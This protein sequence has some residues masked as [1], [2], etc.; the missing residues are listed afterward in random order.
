[1]ASRVC[2]V[3]YHEI[4]LKGNNRARFERILMDNIKAALA[5][6]SVATITRI[7]G[8]ILVTF[9][10]SGEAERAFPLIAKVPGVARVSLAF[11]TNREPGEYCVAAI[12]ALEEFGEFNSFKVVARRSNTDYELTS[13]DL[14]KQVGE[15]LCNAFPDKKV[16]MKGCD[17]QVHVLVVQGSVYVYARSERGVGGLPQGSAGKV[18]TLLSSGIDSPVATWLLARRGAVPVPVHFSGRPQT[19]DTS[20]YLCQDIIQTLA[21]CVQVGRLYVIPFGDCQREI[22]IA[23]PSDLRVI[24]YRRVMYAVAERIA[25]LEGA[26]ALVTGESLGQVA[27][28]TLENIMAVNEVV[29][30]PVFRPLIGSD[31]Q[32][33]I[34]RAEQI[35][36]YDIS[37][38][39]A[40]D[41][42]TLFMP[43]RPETHAKL[44]EVHAAWEMFDHEAMIQQLVD[45]AEYI[46][47]SAPT[48]KPPRC[49]RERHDE[50]EIRYQRKSAEG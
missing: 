12:K 20:E 26:K 6:F 2:L 39:T 21:P 3:H 5:A 25:Q 42:C 33:I 41:C 36:T 43:R 14:N 1:M 45:A 4:G 10:V 24:M 46:D 9:S 16:L 32:E 48:Y 35:G 19:A 13:M 8:H 7:S 29:D 37:T 34:A 40:P 31:K 15:V 18:V 44:D 22:S 27:S 11:H 17:A 49:M 28:Q 47:F 30:I 38:Q 50:L 23:C